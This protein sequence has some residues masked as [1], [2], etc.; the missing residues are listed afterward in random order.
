MGR[1][2]K[3]SLPSSSSGRPQARQIQISS[4]TGQLH[5]FPQKKSSTGGPSTQGEVREGFPPAL[6]PPTHHQL[7]RMRSRVSGLPLRVGTRCALTW[8]PANPSCLCT[9]TRQ[10]LFRDTFSQT[11][12]LPQRL[13]QSLERQRLWGRTWGLG[14]ELWSAW[15]APARSSK[16]EV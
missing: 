15:A 14:T 13:L 5:P 1:R 3:S 6:L 10:S 8:F 7:L 9:F 4:K 12:S 11:P 16:G 2:G